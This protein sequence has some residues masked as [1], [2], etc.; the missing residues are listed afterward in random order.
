M[1]PVRM[2][3]GV[4]LRP[5]EAEG[6]VLLECSHVAED[7]TADHEERHAPFNRFFDVGAGLVDEF[8]DVRQNR[9]REGLRLRDVGI[10]LGIEFLFFHGSLPPRLYLQV[11]SWAQSAP[12]SLD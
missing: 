10:D 2:Q 9:L 8:A 4:H 3:D 5:P 12:A 1:E 11:W 7:D 6:A